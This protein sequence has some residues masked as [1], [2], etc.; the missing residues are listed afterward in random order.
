MNLLCPSAA[1]DKLGALCLSLRHSTAPHTSLDGRDGEAAEREG[2]AGTAGRCPRLGSG[3]KDGAA[4]PGTSCPLA[5]RRGQRLPA[6][7]QEAAV[8]LCRDGSQPSV[9]GRAGGTQPGGNPV[10]V[11]PRAGE[12]SQPGC[13]RPQSGCPRPQPC[14]PSRVPAQRPC[15]P[16]S[17]RVR[18]CQGSRSMEPGSLRS[19]LAEGH[20]ISDVAK[21]ALKGGGPWPSCQP[22]AL[23]LRQGSR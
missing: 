3:V 15:V 9:M 6:R 7:Q 12:P 20:G 23:L 10:A 2:S 21:R 1:A 4:A 17:C 16:V 8:S 19:H 14:P 18:L 11:Q 13:P 22:F 5:G